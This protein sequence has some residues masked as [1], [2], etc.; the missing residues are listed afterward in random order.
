VEFR[1]HRGDGF[2]PYEQGAVEAAWSALGSLAEEGADTLG[3]QDIDR[4]LALAYD[5]EWGRK[6]LERARGAR[7]GFTAEF[8]TFTDPFHDRSEHAKALSERFDT[9]E[10]L[11]RDDADEYRRLV[12]GRSG[13]PL[14]ASGLLIPLRYGQLKFYNAEYDRHLGVFLIDGDYDPVLG[15]RRPPEPETI[16]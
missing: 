2:R 8:L 3:E 9:A 10:V 6:W 16:L 4:L 14:L 13:D 15:L 7:D 1:V 5:T 12:S 11:L